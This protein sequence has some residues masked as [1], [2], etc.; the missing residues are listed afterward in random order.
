MQFDRRNPDGNPIYIIEE[1]IKN[2]C[3]VLEKEQIKKLK[4]Y[5]FNLENKIKSYKYS[6]VPRL[7]GEIEGLKM[8]N[9]RNL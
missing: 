8:R 9:K 4:E 6:I 5:I 7:E 1:K 2:N 3:E